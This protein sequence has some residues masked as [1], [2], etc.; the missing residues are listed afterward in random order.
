[1]N[2]LLREPAAI[3]A[4]LSDG[5]ARARRRCVTGAQHLLRV[6]ES[7]VGYRRL[8]ALLGCRNRTAGFRSACRATAGRGSLTF[9]GVVLLELGES[10]WSGFDIRCQSGREFRKQM[11]NPKLHQDLI[12]FLVV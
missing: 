6:H 8:G 10:L 1:M 9:R 4:V 7:D 12:F 11:S 2:R 5:S 3:D